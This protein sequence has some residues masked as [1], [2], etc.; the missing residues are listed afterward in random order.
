[1]YQFVPLQV[2]KTELGW[3][4]GF[5]LNTTNRIPERRQAYSLSMAVFV[6]LILLFLVFI[7]LSA[8][9]CGYARRV[10][11]HQQINKYQR[12]SNYGTVA[13]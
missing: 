1:M 10:A 3:S 11:K 12:L 13:P 6:L 8:C 4:L 9:F 5:M 7:A 2:E